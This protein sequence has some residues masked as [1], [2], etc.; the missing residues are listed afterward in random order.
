M[1]QKPDDASQDVND[2]TPT[3]DPAPT[4]PETELGGD[5]PLREDGSPEA[6]KPDGAD[7]STSPRPDR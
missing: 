1:S 5:P 2:A 4:P 6:P 3:N 7:P